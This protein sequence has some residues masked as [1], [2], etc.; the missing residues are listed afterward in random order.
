[1]S[2]PYIPWLQLDKDTLTDPRLLTAAQQLTDHLRQTSAGHPA[3]VF[4]LSAVRGALVMLWC[5]AHDH[6]QP[7]D[8]LLL[9]PRTIDSMVGIDGFCSCMPSEWL[10]VINDGTAVKLPHFIDKNGIVK[11]RQQRERDAKRK[12]EARADKRP[13]DIQ[14]TSDDRP[15]DIQ[16]R[17]GRS[18]EREK[19]AK[20]V[21][22]KATR[23]PE[24]WT[25]PAEWRAWA[26]GKGMTDRDVT[27]Q[28][29]R[30][31]D[32]WRGAPKGVK[33][34]WLSTWRNWIRTALDNQGRAR[35]TTAHARPTRQTQES[36]MAALDAA[37]ARNSSDSAYTIGG[38]E[39][40]KYDN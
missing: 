4:V 20:A 21:Q 19:T 37:I 6:I 16:R 13:A 15:Q 23:L 1:V 40:I 14:R 28:A 8:V 27:E 5:Y 2:K 35:T 11:I 34:D 26:I 17:E 36:A 24:T 7:G 10:Q 29:E 39:P 12:R 9:S 3:D 18:I 22:K 30:F 33:T 38:D 32:Y 31:S 25:L